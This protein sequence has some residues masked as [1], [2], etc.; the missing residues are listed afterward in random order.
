MISRYANR[1]IIRISDQ[2]YSEIFERRGIRFVDVHEVAQFNFDPDDL[3]GLT[4]EAHTWKDGDRFFNLAK[5]YYGSERLWWIIAI[6]NQKP[7]EAY[8][9]AGEKIFVPTPLED[10]LAYIGV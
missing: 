2:S 8:A 7:T 1:K 9:N 10:V 6:F 4:I 3:R 5:R